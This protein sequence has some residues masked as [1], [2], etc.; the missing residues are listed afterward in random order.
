MAVEQ[1][2]I[3]DRDDHPIGLKPRPD[4][5]YDDIYRVAMLWATNSRGQILL[6]QRAFVKAQNGGLWGP[7]VGGTV[8]E[9]ETYESNIYKEA[10]EEIGLTG[11]KFKAGPKLFSAADRQKF[12][13]WYTVTLD[14]E[15]SSF[16]LQIEEVEQLEWVEPKA[17]AQDLAAHPERYIPTANQWPGLFI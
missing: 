1:V 17:L 11:L 16:K 4:I 7:A 13:Q 2:I 5:T 8:S 15:L 12:I 6:A 3:V 10:E 14:R 9:G